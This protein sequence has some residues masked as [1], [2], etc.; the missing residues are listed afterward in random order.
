M[1]PQATAQQLL[2]LGP[3]S[4]AHIHYSWTYVHPGQSIGN[5]HSI[6]K[7]YMIGSMYNRYYIHMCIHILFIDCLFPIPLKVGSLLVSIPFLLLG[8]VTRQL[9][10]VKRQLG[11]HILAVEYPGYGITLPCNGQ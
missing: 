11:L 3:W 7:Q 2:G 6:N 4:R 9:R 8:H 5:H 1:G 10:D